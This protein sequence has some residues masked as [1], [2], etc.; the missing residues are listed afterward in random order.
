MQQMPNEGR[1]FRAVDGAW[2]RSMTGVRKAPEVLVACSD[3]ELLK[4]LIESNKLLDQVLH[5][6]TYILNI[7]DFLN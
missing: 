1:K 6:E 3:D 4:S 7:P 2:R 5:V